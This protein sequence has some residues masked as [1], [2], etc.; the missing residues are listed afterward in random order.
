M[1]LSR[2]IVLLV[3]V[4]LS[5]AVDVD[6]SLNCRYD[7]TESIPEG[8]V[9]PEGSIS[10]STFDELYALVKNAQS[11]IDVA[12]FYW[13]LLGTDVM[14]SPDA[15]SAP[16]EALLAAFQE[17]AQRGVHV[18]IAVSASVGSNLTSSKDLS[19]LSEAGAEIRAVNFT[20][21][22]GAG[23]KYQLML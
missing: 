13:T 6:Q 2:C 21:L 17:A 5:S 1:P 11:T 12:S 14:P 19:L 20:R 4:A 16:G 7:L 23:G 8:L 9:F 22:V 15:T 10:N 3:V 18:R